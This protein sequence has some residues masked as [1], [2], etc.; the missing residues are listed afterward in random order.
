MHLIAHGIDLADCHKLEKMIE[1]HG[2]RLLDR[3]FTATEQR[4]CQGHRRCAE[5]FAGRFAVKEAVMKLLGTGWQNGIAW[6]DIETT[7]DPNGSPNVHLHGLVARIATDAGISQIT[8][9]ITHTADLAI[10]SAV[11]LGNSD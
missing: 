6:T 8:V 9:S 5:R 11:A 1:R 7:N 2:Q 10:A 3:L 4:Y